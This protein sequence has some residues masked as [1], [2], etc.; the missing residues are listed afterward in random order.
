MRAFAEISMAAVK[1]DT[2]KSFAER[3]QILEQAVDYTEEH[4]T[5]L[6]EFLVKDNFTPVRTAGMEIEVGQGFLRDFLKKHRTGKP[7]IADPLGLFYVLMP[8][9][10][11]S[12]L[13]SIQSLALF[14]LG[15]TVVV[16]MSSQT[17]RVCAFYKRMLQNLGIQ[18]IQMADGIAGKKFILAASSGSLL[19]RCRKSGTGFIFAGTEQA[20]KAIQKFT[21]NFDVVV[22]NGP[23]NAVAYVHGRTS[24]LEEVAQKLAYAA[25]ANSGQYC[26][27]I[28]TVLVDSE[29]YTEFKELLIGYVE[30]LEVGNP[31]DEKTRVGPVRNRYVRALWHDLVKTWKTRLICGGKCQEA[32]FSG[33]DKGELLYP[34]IIESDTIPTTEI[35]GP[36]LFLVKV[37]G[38]HEALN[39]LKRNPFGLYASFWGEFDARDRAMLADLEGSCYGAVDFNRWI[40]NGNFL[41][42]RFEGD[43]VFQM[44]KGWGGVKRSGF[45]LDRRTSGER[46]YSGRYRPEDIGFAAALDSEQKDL[47][48]RVDI[49]DGQRF[50]SGNIHSSFV[51][52]RVSGD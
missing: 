8:F 32:N 47:F 29:I 10:M 24:G 35:F 3:L 12:V 27:S 4:K 49:S 48:R 25:F 33:L 26:F 51:E 44:K 20:W 40:D 52:K 45:I 9:D 14:A 19:R 37:N 42:E 7:P 34:T 15:N 13:F 1:A 6:M 30:K 5:R 46:I 39:T 31:F 28:K 41:K 18:E 43:S 23:G 17:P 36:V 11:P 16:R 22:F 21:R 50:L 2:E 38:F